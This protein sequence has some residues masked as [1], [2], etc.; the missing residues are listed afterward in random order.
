MSN[1]KIIFHPHTSLDQ[2][3]QP[4]CLLVT[5][6][7]L[8][9][10]SRGNDRACIGSD[11]PGKK[12]QE[13]ISETV[14]LEQKVIK[15]TLTYISGQLFYFCVWVQVILSENQP[16]V[17]SEHTSSSPGAREK[18]Q[19]LPPTRGATPAFPEAQGCFARIWK[20]RFSC[21]FLPFINCPHYFPRPLILCLLPTP[22][23]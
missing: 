2:N 12:G 9:Q 10:C 7:R 22:S 5:G 16:L 6:S 17:S 13:D 20:S 21:L 23:T 4:S 8:G 3:M 1:L 11:P 19:R 18:E 15:E 14:I